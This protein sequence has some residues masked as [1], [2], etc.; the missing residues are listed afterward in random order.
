MAQVE[1]LPRIAIRATGDIGPDRPGSSFGSRELT[2][3]PSRPEEA[4]R[5]HVI[6]VLRCPI[7]DRLSRVSRPAHHLLPIDMGHSDSHHSRVPDSYGKRDRSHASWRL[8]RPDYRSIPVDRGRT[9]STSRTRLPGRGAGPQPLVVSGEM[10]SR[11]SPLPRARRPGYRSRRCSGYLLVRVLFTG[12]YPRVLF[13]YVL[14]VTRWTLRV[15]E[16]AFFL[17]TDEYPPFRLD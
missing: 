3:A 11:H 1:E 15:E 10:V 4:I 17:V 12:R 7:G 2:G 6:R 13:D 8:S 14:G 5:G 9:V 16:Y